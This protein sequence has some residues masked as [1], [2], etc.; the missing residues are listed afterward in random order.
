[1]TVLTM[2]VVNKD[3][4]NFTDNHVHNIF[5]IFDGLAN[6]SFTRSERKHVY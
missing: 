6:Y 3:I 4:K 2:K 5:R 1:M